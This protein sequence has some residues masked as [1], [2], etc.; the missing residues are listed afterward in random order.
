L[1]SRLR[2]RLL[3]RQLGELV[4]R[5]LSLLLRE[6]PLVGGLE[7]GKVS[8]VGDERSIRRAG[9]LDQCHAASRALHERATDAQLSRDL[10]QLGNVL[11]AHRTGIVN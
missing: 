5:L 11:L 7:Q 9:N 4:L 6:L 8:V 2:H 10:F 1:R 3:P